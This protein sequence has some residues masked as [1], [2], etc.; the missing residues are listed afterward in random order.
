MR[1]RYHIGKLAAV[2]KLR[3][4]ELGGGRGTIG[5]EN[6]KSLKA[7]MKKIIITDAVFPINNIDADAVLG[8]PP[9]E[10]TLGP[11]QEYEDYEDEDE[12]VVMGGGRSSGGGRLSNSGGR[13]SV[14]RPVSPTSGTLL[15]RP[16]NMKPG[17]RFLTIVVEK[18]GF[19]EIPYF[20]EPQVVISVRSQNGEVIESIQETPY[21]KKNS[22]TGAVSSSPNYVYFENAVKIQTPLNKMGRKCAIFFEFRHYKED[23]KYKSIKCYSFMEMDEIRPGPIALEVYRKP[24]VFNT[25]VSHNLLSVKSHVLCHLSLSIETIPN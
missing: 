6:M 3:I 20:T 22:G 13:T 24:T 16:T 8:V 17:E 4:K 14:S 15:G 18:W 5:L 12:E 11:Q 19:K 9:I 23:K 21:G 10:D 7:Y 2:L 1:R 25:E